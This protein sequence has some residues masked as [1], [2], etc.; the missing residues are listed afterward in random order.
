MKGPAVLAIVFT[1]AAGIVAAA[2]IGS[3][4]IREAL[5][6]LDARREWNDIKRRSDACRYLSDIRPRS[7]R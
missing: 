2:L 5:D 7:V 3:S 4:L 1:V 6:E